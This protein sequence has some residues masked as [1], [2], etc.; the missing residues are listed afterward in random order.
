MT[1]I[2]AADP[3]A[4]AKAAAILQEGGLV[5]MPTETV[6]GLAANAL[7]GRAVAKVYAAKGRPQFNPLIAHFGDAPS[8]VQHA[9]FDA[10][11]HLLAQKFWP[12]PLTLVL[13]RQASSAIS[14]LATA[15]LDTIAIRVPAHRV[16]QQ[17]IRACGFPLVAPSANPSTGLSPTTPLHVARGLGAA[18]DMILAAGPCAIGLES[19]VIDLSGPDAVLLRPGAITVQQIEDVLQQKILSATKDHGHKSPGMMEK[20][21]AP[22]VPLRLKAVDVAPGEA[23]LAFGSLRFMGLRGGGAA[24]DLPESRLR[25]LSESG[26]LHEAAANLFAMLHDLDRPEHSAIAIMDIPE[27]GLG[28]AI[29]D[30]LRRGAVGI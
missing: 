19:T 21:Y 5:A 7:D 18:V 13:P 1:R 30:R 10:R 28:I 11:A 29:N 23:L 17:L 2:L 6:Y 24:A 16:A 26:D 25:N 9:E 15:G 12:G 3:A 22:R 4:I 14:T 8:A 27:S 20:H